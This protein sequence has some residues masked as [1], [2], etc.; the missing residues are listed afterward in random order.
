M[1]KQYH[2]AGFTLIELMIVVAIIGIIAAIAM[3]AYTGYLHR[4]RINAVKSNFD[5][6][7]NFIKNENAKN[8]GGTSGASTNVV[9]TLNEGTLKRSI[10]DPVNATAFV[11]AVTTAAHSIAINP[12]N[13][14]V[15]G[16]IVVYAPTSPIG[17]GLQDVTITLE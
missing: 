10:T 16:T 17:N 8:A 11:A 15:A 14:R 3:P 6:A 12:T 13:A 2:T 9:D 4:S 7:I 1:I 5:L